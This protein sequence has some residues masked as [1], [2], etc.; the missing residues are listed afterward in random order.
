MARGLLS[1]L[2]GEHDR[3]VSSRAAEIYE[4]SGIDPRLV[5][6]LLIELAAQE[7]LLYRAYSRGI[8]LKIDERIHNEHA[9]STIEGR[10]GQRYEYFAKRM[11]HMLDYIRLRRDQNRCRS[12]ELINYLTGENNAPTCGKCDLCSPKNTELPWKP[13]VR[14]YGERLEVDV[15]LAVLGTIRDHN[16]VYGRGHL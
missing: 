14:L 2:K 10:F 4:S 12:A 7:L 16:G 1:A 5:D 15:R 11:Q 6:P 3:Q 9:L 13:N 8:T